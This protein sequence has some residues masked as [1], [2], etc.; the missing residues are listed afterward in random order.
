LTG[1]LGGNLAVVIAATGDGHSATVAMDPDLV[2]LRRSSARP[3]QLCG[4]WLERHGTFRQ[5][6]IITLD[7]DTKTGGPGSALLLGISKRVYA[8]PVETLEDRSERSRRPGRQRRTLLGR[9]RDPRPPS[10]RW[11]LTFGSS[12]TRS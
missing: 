7:S 2:R 4:A 1:Y 11:V 8:G 9:M 5:A 10:D 12:P 6:R 3:S